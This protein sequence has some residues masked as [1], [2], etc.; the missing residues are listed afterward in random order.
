[1]G[2]G[3][4]G[5]SL[6]EMG[7][8]VK[9]AGKAVQKAGGGVIQQVKQ[10]ATGQTPNQ[11]PTTTPEP[12]FE[13]D[14][15]GNPLNMFQAAGKQVIG[16]GNKPQSSRPAQ[17]GSFVMPKSSGN[18]QNPQ[19]PSEASPKQSGGFDLASMLG[20][21]MGAEG[22]FGTPKQSSPNS[23]NE[24]IQQEFAQRR[25]EDQVQIERLRKQ[26]H[27]MYY[28]EFAKK[29]EGKDQKKEETVQE[30]LEREK[31]EEEQKKMKELEEKKKKED[32]PL[33]VKGRQGAHEGL[34]I[35]G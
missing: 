32:V 5:L 28:E 13:T 33:S 24:K 17:Q 9:K 14:D 30:K 11:T 7:I 1:M 8:A 4:S 10:Q 18:T 20:G 12:T 19:V 27:Q 2:D 22:G 26:L 15:S 21:D 6:S 3:A 16:G 29:A 34:K 25:E 23:Q 31:Q 35:Q